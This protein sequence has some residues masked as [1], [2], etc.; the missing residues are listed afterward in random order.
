M[1][2]GVFPPL[3]T[4]F[5]DD[6]I[7][8][9]VMA[10]TVN[11]LMETGLAGVLLLGT[12]G[13]ASLVTEAEADHLVTLTR[14][15]VPPGRPLLVGTGRDGTAATIDACRRAGQ[16]G[17]T[18]ALVRPP[19]SYTPLMT[20]EVL[21][22]HDARVAD[23]SPIP[24]L[25]YNQPAVFGPDLA[26]ATVASLAAHG[27]IVGIKDSSGNIA[28]VS[29]VLSRVPPEFDVLTGVA[30]IMYASLLSGTSGSVIAVANVVPALCVRLF[31]FVMAGELHN[32]L[33]LQRALAP[34]ARAVTAQYGV[35]G[36][37]AAMTLVG[38]PVM[39]PRRPLLP[40]PA[41]A[42]DEIARLLRTLEEFTQ[43]RL[44]AVAS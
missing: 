18:H 17:A 35:P 3:P 28:Q 42:V 12:N 4:A 36:L 44:L 34:L 33:A 16:Q 43:V 5:T 38:H 1:L 25:L 39:T 11:R 27:N 37:K 29:D 23:A 41:T 31:D 9:G 6:R 15:V 24:V 20:Q 8:D 30:A 7:D 14:R 10:E 32:A 21:R 26:P 19:T 2:R 13:E 40:A 22:T